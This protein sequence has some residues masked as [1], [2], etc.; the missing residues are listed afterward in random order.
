MPEITQG[1]DPEALD[2]FMVDFGASLAGWT[3][4]G[5]EDDFQPFDIK[6]LVVIMT[7]ALGAFA[8]R[9]KDYDPDQDVSET[10]QVGIYTYGKSVEANFQAEA[11]KLAAREMME[12][13]PQDAG[14][15]TDPNEEDE[16]PEE[17]YDDPS[18]DP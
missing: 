10:I 6:Q 12:F 9:R 7:A 17:A 2:T 18:P 15:F 5:T 1:M 8:L 13:D 11:D 3:V 14:V 16:P 4:Y